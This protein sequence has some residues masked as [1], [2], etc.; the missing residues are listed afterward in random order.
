MADIRNP[1]GTELA[2]TARAATPV[3][4]EAV[5]AAQRAFFRAALGQASTP[6]ATTQNAVVAAVQPTLVRPTITTSAASS[7]RFD[8]QTPPTRLLRPGSL[9]DIKI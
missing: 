1:V 9:I 7:G 8:P 2:P 4:T 6:Q 3:A 5:R